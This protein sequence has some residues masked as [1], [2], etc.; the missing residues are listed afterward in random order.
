MNKSN[1]APGF[2]WDVEALQISEDFQCSLSATRDLV[3][4]SW[5]RAGD[6]R[7][8]YDWILCGHRPAQPILQAIAYM[9]LRA[10]GLRFDPRQTPDPALASSL[11]F[12]LAV[13]GKGRRLPDLER[14]GRDRCIA[15]AVAREMALGS[16]YDAAISAV[17]EWLPSAGV[18]LSRESVEKAYKTWGSKNRQSVS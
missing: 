9:M 17:H 6:T 13:K 1:D 3:I 7:P 11:P 12:G 14:V 18:H 15:R 8:F 2:L 5:L 16:K 10:D 4:L